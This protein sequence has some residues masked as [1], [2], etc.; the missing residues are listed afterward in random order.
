M[1]TEQTG[2]MQQAADI[3]TQQEN[4]QLYKKQLKGAFPMQE[5][6]L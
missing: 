4:T 6:R 5:A 2:A 3:F 1:L